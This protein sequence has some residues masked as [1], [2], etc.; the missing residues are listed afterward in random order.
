MQLRSAPLWWATDNPDGDYL[1]VESVNQVMSLVTELIVGLEQRFVETILLLA[2]HGDTL[3]IL[4]TVFAGRN[5]S[6][7]RQLQHLHTADTRC[8]RLA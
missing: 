2:S 1:T 3:Q 8:F 4:H 6:T 7:H 5:A